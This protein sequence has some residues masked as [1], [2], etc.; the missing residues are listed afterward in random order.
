[1]YFFGLGWTKVEAIDSLMRKAGYNGHITD[2]VRKRIM[3]TRYQSTLCTMHY[4][5]YVAYVKAARGEAP[6]IV[7]AK[8]G[9][10]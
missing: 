2:S 6:S 4:G 10:N 7:G 3:L 8:P 9:N 1:M 5:E